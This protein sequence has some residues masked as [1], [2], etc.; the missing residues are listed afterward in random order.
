MP[1]GENV[2]VWNPRVGNTGDA[3]YEW[4]LDQ[5]LKIGTP[6]DWI[7]P[8]IDLPDYLSF[9]KPTLDEVNRLC[10][11][12]Q[13]AAEYLRRIPYVWEIGGTPGFSPANFP[14]SLARDAVVPIPIGG[15]PTWWTTGGFDEYPAVIGRALVSSWFSRRLAG[16][17]PNIP[18]N[19]I[20]YLGGW[21]DFIRSAELYTGSAMPLT[22]T[23]QPVTQV[24]MSALRK[25][26]AIDHIRARG[27]F[28]FE[29]RDQMVDLFGVVVAPTVD[30]ISQLW[31]MKRSGSTYPPTGTVEREGGSGIGLNSALVGQ[32]QNLAGTLFTK[33]RLYVHFL[34]PNSTPTLSTG[35]LRLSCGRLVGQPAADLRLYDAGSYYDLRTGGVTRPASDWVLGTLLA[36]H[37]ITVGGGVVELSFSAAGLTPG[38]RTFVITTNHEADDT[39]PPTPSDPSTLSE[40][41]GV[42]FSGTNWGFSIGGTL[43]AILQLYTSDAPDSSSS[44]ECTE[45]P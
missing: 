30:N 25:L 12:N 3:Q 19:S 22:A 45:F 7:S 8:F 35:V 17:R 27:L 13:I 6:F 16:A 18:G 41:Y 20:P 34:I 32:F 21:I 33:R 40:E 10:G 11:Y 28:H 43:G 42:G 24:F 44:S 36:T 1:A 2:V 5:P 39:G 29:N 38:P 4:P 9:T 23:V 26:L 15:I 14:P 37:T 31:A